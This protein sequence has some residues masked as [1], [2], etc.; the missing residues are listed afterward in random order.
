M[1]IDMSAAHID[2]ISHK[3]FWREREPNCKSES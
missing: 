3:W 2:G 1:K